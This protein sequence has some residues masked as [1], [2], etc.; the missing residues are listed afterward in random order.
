MF[1]EKYYFIEDKEILCSNSN[2]EYN[3]EECIDLFLEKN[4]LG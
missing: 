3:N 4:R 2:E 1:L